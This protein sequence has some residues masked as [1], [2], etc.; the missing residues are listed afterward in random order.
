MARAL[1]SLSTLGTHARG[2][3]ILRER[4]GGA[5]VQ[6]VAQARPGLALRAQVAD[7]EFELRV[8]GAD[9]TP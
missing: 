4:E 6:S 9:D 8:P 2:Y 3:A 5:L 7:G 1:H